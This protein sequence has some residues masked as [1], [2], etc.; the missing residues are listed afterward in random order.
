MHLPP[1]FWNHERIL[2]RYS[3][4]DGAG[5]ERVRAATL[6]NELRCWRFGAQAFDHV[7]RGSLDCR[8]PI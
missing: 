7:V 5:I 6:V 4:D 3:C 8:L 1:T 2:L